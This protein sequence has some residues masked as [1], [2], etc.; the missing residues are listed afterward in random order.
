MVALAMTA[1][2]L[3]GGGELLT[4]ESAVSAIL[5]VSLDPGSSHAFT[6][7]RI[8]EGVIGGGVALAVSALLFP[9]DPALAVARAG[10]AVFAGLGASL[11]RLAT[12]LRAGDPTAAAEALERARAL[13]LAEFQEALEAGRETARLS[14]RRRAA[15]TAL[16]RYGTSF[17]QVDYA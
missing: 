16:E 10:Q 13:D 5:I 15:L 17:G 1:A 12:A 8:L 7:N 9:P 4:A 2:V 3:L 11:E 6:A 14:P